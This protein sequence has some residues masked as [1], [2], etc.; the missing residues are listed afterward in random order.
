MSKRLF[1]AAIMVA[2]VLLSACTNTQ[3]EPTPTPSPTPDAFARL[4]NEIA[5]YAGAEAT[6]ESGALLVT[7]TISGADKAQAATAFFEQ[8]ELICVNA[9]RDTEYT[10]VSFTMSVND[11]DV[12]A[13]FIMLRE[14]SMVAMPPMAYDPDYAEALED[15]F[16]SSGFAYGEEW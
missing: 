10:E 16:M 2:V 3:P 9:L 5:A 6:E 15:A 1:A 7:L 13:F 12:G 14:A 11:E 4:Q 8:A